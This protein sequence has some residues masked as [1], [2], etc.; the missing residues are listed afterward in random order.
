[1]IMMKKKAQA[2][3]GYWVV[4]S[5][6]IYKLSMFIFSIPTIFFAIGTIGCLIERK[7]AKASILYYIIASVFIFCVI[8]FIDNMYRYRVP[9]MPA[10][11]IITAYGVYYAFATTYAACRK[12]IKTYI[13]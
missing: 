6:P 8:F 9:A 3:L 10:I 11:Y 1:M 4:Y 7:I 5:S 12:I 13:N 2:F